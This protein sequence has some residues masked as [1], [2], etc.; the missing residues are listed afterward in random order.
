MV[1]RVF[2]NLFSNAIKFTS[3]QLIISLRRNQQFC[4]LSVEDDG[5]GI[6]E[7]NQNRIWERFYQIDYSRNKESNNGFGL[8]LAMVKKIMQ[9]HD[10]E[11]NVKTKKSGGS[12]FTVTFPVVMR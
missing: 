7:Q 4:Y 12:I 2:D 9:L 5:P 6:S 3:T 11:A 8:G 10:G 1:Q